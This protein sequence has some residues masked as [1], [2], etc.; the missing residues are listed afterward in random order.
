MTQ[1]KIK[2]GWRKKVLS[3]IAKG[4]TLTQAAQLSQVGMDKIIQHKNRDEEFAA[5]LKQAEANRTVKNVQ[6]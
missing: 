1:V 5:E 4:R 2:P 6:W 3:H